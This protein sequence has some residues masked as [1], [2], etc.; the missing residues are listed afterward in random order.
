MR[1]WMLEIHNT[2]FY[3][4]YHQFFKFC[5]VGCTNFLIGIIVYYLVLGAFGCFPAGKTSGNVI[6]GFLFRYDY[7][8]AN[9]LSFIISV[10][11]AYVLNRVWVFRK[12]AQ[13]AAHGAVFR[14]FASYGFTFLLALFLAWV[15]V[16]IAAVSKVYVPFLNVLITTPINFFLSKYFSFRKK[17]THTAGVELSPY[18]ISEEGPAGSG[19]EINHRQ[20][21][22][23]K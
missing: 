12:E 15:W 11:N 10:L 22:S 19:T 23:P 14:F 1:K 7:Q 20:G 5:I 18:E 16:E 2:K 17:K 13:K 6:V 8:I 3:K 4:K 9:I 21:V